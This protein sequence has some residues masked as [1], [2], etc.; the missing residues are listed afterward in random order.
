M[1]PCNNVRVDREIVIGVDTHKEFHVAVAL[2]MLGRRLCELSVPTSS[3]GYAM[4]TEWAL[5][6]GQPVAWGVEGTGS[7]GAALTRHLRQLGLRVLEVDRPNRQARRK[8]GKDDAIDAELAAR[9]VL[10]GT[11]T[12]VP[13]VTDG[14]A[15]MI[16]L[17]KLTR[18]SAV[19]QRTQTTCQIEAVLVT[20]P[21]ALREQLRGLPR[22]QLI[23]TCARFRVIATPATVLDAARYTLRTLARRYQA[24][25]AEADE[26]TR[27]IT[28]LV[29]TYAP[30]LM[31]HVGVGPDNAAALLLTVGDNPTRMRSEAA[32]AALCGVS[33]VPASSG[34]TRRH[35]L[36]RGGDRQAN[37]ALHRIVIVRMQWHEPTKQ[38]VERRIAEGKQRSEI[39]RCLKRFTARQ[40]Y[41]ILTHAR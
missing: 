36:N 23:A 16:R 31:D 5:D 13:K 26:L 22:K 37:C 11:A 24:L 41:P 14:P 18:D 27:Q 3:D 15:E 38:Y 33:P 28:G 8:L 7:F 25:R 19:K 10:A 32:F 40:L 29:Q 21:D 20:A 6:Q 1:P 35:R 34:N 39:I 12:T 2:D 9:A 4:L 30:G 17:L